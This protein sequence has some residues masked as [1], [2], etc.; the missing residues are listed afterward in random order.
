[1]STVRSIRVIYA[2]FGES[3]DVYD[4]GGSGSLAVITPCIDESGQLWFDL[5]DNDGNLTASINGRYVTVICYH[6]PE[7]PHE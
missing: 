7:A 5:Y 1:M 4:V 3:E 2:R 6:V